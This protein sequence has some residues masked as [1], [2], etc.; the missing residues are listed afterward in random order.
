MQINLILCIANS[1]EPV[2][3]KTGDIHLVGGTE[4]YEGRLEICINQVWGTICSRNWDN[5]ETKVTC[6]QLGFQELG[7]SLVHNILADIDFN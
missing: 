2:N 7:L 3:C 4:D 5:T 1:T 6:R